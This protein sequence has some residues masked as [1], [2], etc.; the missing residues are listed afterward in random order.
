MDAFDP[1][2]SDDPPPALNLLAPV[3]GGNINQGPSPSAA[4]L[5]IS[6][7]P[8]FPS[9]GLPI[10]AST[11]SDVD[12]TLGSNSTSLTNDGSQPFATGQSVFPQNSSSMVEE[13]SAGSGAADLNG[14][15]TYN[16]ETASFGEPLKPFEDTNRAGE[17]SEGFPGL[18]NFEATLAP[19][20]IVETNLAAGLVGNSKVSM[21][22]KIGLS[23]SFKRGRLDANSIQCSMCSC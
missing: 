15:L 17:T 23:T 4:P 21:K 6:V 16:Y 13:T 10:G 12:P 7:N 8:L 11:A 9:T 2:G 22:L 20:E 14:A 18:G 3:I 19:A 5:P 1:F